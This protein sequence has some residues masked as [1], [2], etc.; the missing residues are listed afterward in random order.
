MIQMKKFVLYTLILLL[1]ATCAGVFGILLPYHSAQTAMAEEGLILQEQED[2]TLFLQ[3]PEAKHA[4]RYQIEILTDGEVLYREFSD[5]ASGFSL[6]ELPED[7]QLTLRVQAL[8]DYKTLLGEGVRYS[9]NAL[10]AVLPHRLPRLKVLSVYPD[11]GEQSVTLVVDQTDTS[12]WQCRVVDDSGKVLLDKFVTDPF[13]VIPFGETGPALPEENAPYQLQ[14][15][16]VLEHDGLLC[17]GPVSRGGSIT[18]E[19]LTVWE[20]TLQTHTPSKYK[21]TFTWNE[22]RRADYAIQRLEQNDWITVSKIFDG[23]ARSYT[24]PWLNPGSYEYRIVALDAGGTELAVTEPEP[25]LIH[26]LTKYATVW[27]VRD[28]PVYSDPNW[29]SIADSVKQGQAF[30]VLDEINGMFAIEVN[31]QIRYI[32]SNYCMINLPEYMGD[33]CSYNIT[34]SVSSIYAVHEFGIPEVTGVVSPGYE[35]IAQEDGSFLVPLLYPTAKKLMKAAR[36]AQNQGYRLKIYDSFRPY[37]TTRDIYDRTELILNDP[38]P[39]QTYTGLPRSAITDLPEEPKKGFDDLTYGWVMTGN[40]YVLGAFL[41][42]TGSSHNLGIALDLTLE[43]LESG[44]EIPMQTAIHDLSQYSVLGTN[45]DAAD[46]LGSIM[47]GAGFGGLISEWWHFQDNDAKEHLKL[48]SVTNGVSAEC[49]VKDDQGW[50]WRDAKGRFFTGKT[51]EIGN[52]TYTFD[53]DGYRQN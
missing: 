14:A 47:H 43:D 16:P 5:R 25:V 24:T 7:R 28:V 38:L 4:D 9:D 3:W 2:G 20:L 31:G 11:A 29:I 33:L 35:D 12:G 21:R 30:C 45:N 34:N 13:L 36:T 19:D 51:L 17:Y 1:L 40:N 48:L 37:I 32:N 50:R 46:L 39:Q 41:A 52:E 49:W 26:D 18:L 44:V 42:R 8:A 10:E 23:E 22:V 15:M 6:P 27:P 53:A